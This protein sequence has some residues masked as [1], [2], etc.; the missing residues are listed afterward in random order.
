M[1]TK[2]STRPARSAKK[3]AVRSGLSN[4]GLHQAR[5]KVGCDIVTLREAAS[6]TGVGESELIEAL[7]KRKSRALLLGYGVW[8]VDLVALSEEC[9]M[10]VSGSGIS[11]LESGYNL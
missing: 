3:P 11:V 5:T 9:D 2:A 6:R 4:K 8:L 7:T 10:E 1:G